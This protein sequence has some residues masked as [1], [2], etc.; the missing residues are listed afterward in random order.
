MKGLVIGL[1]VGFVL[2]VAMEG[3]AFGSW[4]S[5]AELVASGESLRLGYAAGARDML[6]AVVALSNK[7]SDTPQL[8]PQW[9]SKQDKCL[10]ARSKGNLRQFT[11][12]AENL[13]RGREEDA[14]SILLDGAC[15]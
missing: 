5:G 2:G 4:F 1:V 12:F 11:D 6:G 10:A 8:P 9:F 3:F 13:W 7:W 15:K 14:A